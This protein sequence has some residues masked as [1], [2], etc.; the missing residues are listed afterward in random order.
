MKCWYDSRNQPYFYLMPIKIEQHAH[1]PALYTLHHVLSDDE[2]EV[3]K[4]LAKPLVC[5]RRADPSA[6]TP[7]TK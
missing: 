4:E 2:I 7:L 1:D 5:T 6:L 3:I